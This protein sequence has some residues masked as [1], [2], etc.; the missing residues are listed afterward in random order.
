MTSTH[1]WCNKTKNPNF[2]KW[3]KKYLFIICL[4]IHVTV[5]VVVVAVAAA[6]AAAAAYTFHVSRDRFLNKYG[7]QATEYSVFRVMIV[8]TRKSTVLIS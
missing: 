6:A 3:R 7:R 4:F 8:V 2:V 5:V 1:K